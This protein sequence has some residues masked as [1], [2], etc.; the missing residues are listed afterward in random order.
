D[1]TAE[2]GDVGAISA[3]YEKDGET[4]VLPVDADGNVTVPAGVTT[5]SVSVKTTDDDVY[6]GDE[7]FGL[8]V[9]ES[10]GVTSNGSVTGTAT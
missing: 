3:S 8:V 4:I 9:T 7:T 5:I 1:Y 6:E 10:N 2:E